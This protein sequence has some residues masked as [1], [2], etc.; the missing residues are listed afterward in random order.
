MLNRGIVPD[1]LVT[2]HADPEWAR[3]IRLSYTPNAESNLSRLMVPDPYVRL[4]VALEVLRAK[5]EHLSGSAVRCVAHANRIDIYCGEPEPPAS[6]EPQ[7]D[8]P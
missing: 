3:A 4:D 2:L 6:T 8:L 5:V 1:V 7:T